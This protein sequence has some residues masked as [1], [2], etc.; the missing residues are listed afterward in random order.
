MEKKAYL[1]QTS[2][3]KKTIDDQKNIH[4]VSCFDMTNLTIKTD[5]FDFN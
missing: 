4:F 3:T 5:Q 2:A 1:D